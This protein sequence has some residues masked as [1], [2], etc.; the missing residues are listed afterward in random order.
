MLIYI[1][2]DVCTEICNYRGKIRY[3]HTCIY[4]YIDDIHFHNP[5][6]FFVVVV[7]LFSS[8]DLDKRKMSE[9]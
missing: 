4:A 2:L 5:F 8:F 9:I 7:V 3:V 6:F 1:Y